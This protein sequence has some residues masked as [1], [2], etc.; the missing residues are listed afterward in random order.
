LQQKCGDGS[1][2]VN[3]IEQAFFAALGEEWWAVTTV[4]L[5]SSSKAERSLG[6]EQDAR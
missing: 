5:E 1:G 4:V 3:G 2:I 6:C